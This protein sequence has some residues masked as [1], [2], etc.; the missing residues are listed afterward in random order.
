MGKRSRDKDYGT[1]Q[2]SVPDYSRAHLG[3]VGRHALLAAILLTQDDLAPEGITC[4][5]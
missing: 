1:F 3:A 4:I 5:P 2:Q